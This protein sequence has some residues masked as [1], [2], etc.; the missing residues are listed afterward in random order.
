MTKAAAHWTGFG[1]IISGRPGL[2]IT[3]SFLSDIA[4]IRALKGQAERR[5]RRK[6]CVNRGPFHICNLSRFQQ[7]FENCQILLDPF[8]IF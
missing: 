2:G 7:F 4:S 6:S 3:F 1:G 5:P 8:G